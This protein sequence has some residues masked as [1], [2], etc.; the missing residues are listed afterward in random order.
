VK[1]PGRLLDHHEVIVNATL[2]DEGA[3]LFLN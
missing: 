1:Q 3:L 2:L